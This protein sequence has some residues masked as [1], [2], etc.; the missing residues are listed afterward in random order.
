MLGVLLPA[1][2]GLCAVS[3]AD[4]EAWGHESS[5]QRRCHREGVG[6]DKDPTVRREGER[7]VSEG[8][9]CPL[10]QPSLPALATFA[11]FPASRAP[12]FPAGLDPSYLALGHERGH[13]SLI[14]GAA[15]RGGGGSGVSDWVQGTTRR[16]LR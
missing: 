3:P 12:S 7:W 14:L 10:R 16:R 4:P 9:L 2:K 8:G 15:R 13:V 6:E 11:R 5:E 1:V